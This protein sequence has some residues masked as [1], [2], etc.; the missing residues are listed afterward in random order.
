MVST[1]S[2]VNEIMSGAEQMVLLMSLQREMNEMRKKNEEEI[3][4]LLKENEEMKKLTEEGP[5][6]GPNNLAGKSQTTPTNTK[7]ANSYQ[8]A[9]DESYLNKSFSKSDTLDISR[10]HPFTGYVMG[11]SYRSCVRG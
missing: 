4:A 9:E 1:R 7:T 3:L 6:G 5:S 10:R 2:M 11:R 8:E